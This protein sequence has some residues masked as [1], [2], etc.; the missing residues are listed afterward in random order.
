[1]KILIVRNKIST[2]VIKSLRLV[3][4]MNLDFLAKIALHISESIHYVN[5]NH[6]TIYLWNADQIIK[7]LNWTFSKNWHKWFIFFD[8]KK[9]EPSFSVNFFISTAITPAFKC[10][11]GNH[12]RET[13]WNFHPWRIF[14]LKCAL[15]NKLQ[16][17][18]NVTFHVN[19]D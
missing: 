2:V 10:V 9:I 19:R 3:M 14:N 12:K 7:V 11:S 4:K 15:G 17:F 8:I 5:F 16:V 6:K 18:L 1:M 13:S